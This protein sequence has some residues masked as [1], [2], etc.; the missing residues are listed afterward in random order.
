MQSV[1]ILLPLLLPACVQARQGWLSVIASPV[2]EVGYRMT[3]YSSLQALIS[4][5]SHP[6]D[7]NSEACVAHGESAVTAALKLEADRCGMG[8]LLIGAVPV[9]ELLLNQEQPVFILNGDLDGLTRMSALA[10][11]QYQLTASSGSKQQNVRFGVV[12][13]ASHHSFVDEAAPPPAHV[14]SLDL[15]AEVS[16]QQA[17]LA[18]AKI[19]R[20]FFALGHISATGREAMAQ[21]ER[22]FVALA[23]PVQDALKLEGSSA[24]GMPSCNSDVPTNPQCNYPKYPDH[25]LPPGPAPAP[26]PL[27]PSNCICG[28]PWVMQTGSLLSANLGGCSNPKAVIKSSDAFHDVSDTHPFH[29]PHIWNACD[30]T[31]VCVLNTT[32]VTMPVLKAG[33][34]FPASN[35]PLSAYELK[36]K[37]KS[38]EAIWK[39]AAGGGSPKDDKNYTICKSINQAAYDW[40]L[41]HADPLVKQR[42]LDAGELY[43]FV[44]DVEAPIG[45][46]GPEWIQDEL[47]YTRV[48]DSSKAGSHISVQSWTFVV[49]NTANGNLPWFFPVGMHY[50]KLLS[51]ARAMEW[52]YLDGL[53]RSFGTSAANK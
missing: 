25:A 23:T 41:A 3:D 52:I 14:H 11:L 50:C 51:P 1:K 20:E 15:R 22:S 38:R 18:T 12:R 19:A 49:S 13:G 34:L 35:P 4:H 28:S 39:A 46:G 16:H 24:L 8:K 29:L 36:T 6:T 53:R 32:T 48:K 42:F 37:F 9:L 27:P 33:D 43:Q 47:N 17:H 44:D 10:A 30:G 5:E 31:S 40:A 26:S 21:A 2:T 45:A 7:P